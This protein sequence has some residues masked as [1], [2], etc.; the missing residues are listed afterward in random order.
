LTAGPGWSV[1]NGDP[2][3]TDAGGDA[4]FEVSCQTP[5]TDPLSAA[6]GAN[7]PVALGVPPC[8]PPP[9]TSTTRAAT[10]TT[11]PCPTSTV[12]P[13]ASTTTPPATTTTTTTLAFGGC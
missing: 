9:T 6:V 12:T 13:G 7:P 1:Y 8:T 5:G 3:N 10:T 2:Q 4:L 11:V